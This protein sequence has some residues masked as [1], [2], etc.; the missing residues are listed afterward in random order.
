MCHDPDDDMHALYPPP[1]MDMGPAGKGAGW[2]GPVGM[3]LLSTRHRRSDLG[4]RVR[5]RDG[6]GSE[7]GLNPIPRNVQYTSNVI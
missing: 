7:S 2:D 5:V 6:V 4:G 1:T 3:T